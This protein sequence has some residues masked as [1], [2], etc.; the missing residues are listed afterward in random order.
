MREGMVIVPQQTNDGRPLAHLQR[1]VIGRMVEAFGGATVR[2]AQGAWRDAMSGTLY[3]EP[4][5]EIVSAYE[6]EDSADEILRD[7]GLDVAAKGEQLAVYIRLAS[8]EV[9]F[10][11]GAPVAQAI[12]A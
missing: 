8:G 6:P 4:V 1:H 10:L 12:A 5:W 9:E 11:E 3:V 7:I 2:E